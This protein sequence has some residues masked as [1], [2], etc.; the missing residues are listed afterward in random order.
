MT[1]KLNQKEETKLKKVALIYG[2]SIDELVNSVI[3][4]VIDRLYGIPEESLSEY[5]NA[6]EIEKAYQKALKDDSAGNLLSSLPKSVL[7]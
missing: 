1:I 2:I 7:G 4:Q 5:K 6:T 3:S